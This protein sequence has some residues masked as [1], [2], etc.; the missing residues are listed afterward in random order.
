MRHN[1]RRVYL[2]YAATTPVDLRVADAMSRCLTSDSLFGNPSSHL[3]S[4]GQEA[5]QAVEGAR[6]EV[7]ELVGCRVSNV[8]FTSGATEADNAAIKGIASSNHI[9]GRHLVTMASEHKAVLMSCKN[10]ERSGWRISYLRP[11]LEGRLR[12]DELRA[13]LTSD[14]ALVSVMHVNNETGVIQDLQRISEVVHQTEALLHVDA[15]Q[16][17]GKIPVSLESLDVD[18]LSVSA[19]KFYGPKGVGV[20]VVG[21]RAR[22]MLV[23][24]IDGGGQESGFRSGTLATH[25]IIG[26]GE[27]SR[28]ARAEMKPDLERIADLRCRFIDRVAAKTGAILNSGGTTT[29]PGILNISFPHVD[30]FVLLNAL[31]DVAASAASACTTGTLEPSHVLRSMGIEGDRLYGAVR[32]SFGRFTTQ[33]HIDFA[34][35]RLTEEIRRLR[36][37]AA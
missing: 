1:N 31:A 12:V 16:S 10:L 8:V 23:P 6:R 30:A 9:P 15:A 18:L 13:A 35:C 20:L 17:V 27:A 26:L 21:D 33:E 5:S 7:S 37:L 3:Y 36:D 2:D 14:T 29:Y 25:Q 19:H 11:D 4:Y 24:Q 22:E 28:I 32:F 34:C